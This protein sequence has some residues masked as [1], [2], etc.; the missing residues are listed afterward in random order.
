MPGEE[1]PILEPMDTDENP[2]VVPAF[3][4]HGGEVLADG[5][6][7]SEMLA[8]HRAEAETETRIALGTSAIF[9]QLREY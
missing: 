6:V 3:V 9:S 8:L 5:S 7:T 4:D 1:Q 2:G